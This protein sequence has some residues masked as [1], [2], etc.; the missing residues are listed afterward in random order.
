M[1]L[2]SSPPAGHSYA[3]NAVTM[4]I[5]R[6]LLLVAAAAAESQQ[7]AVAGRAQARWAPAAILQPL[8]A[9][10]PPTLPAMPEDLH[11]QAA[12]L[13]ALALLAQEW[14]AVAVEALLVAKLPEVCITTNEGVFWTKAY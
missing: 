3:I 7:G 10:P 8:A 6:H 11:P 14:E 1:I 5:R 12:Q 4:Q 13:A 9:T 2:V